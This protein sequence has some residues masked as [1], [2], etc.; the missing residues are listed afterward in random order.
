MS[1][2]EVRRAKDI[3]VCDDC[4]N[5]IYINENYYSKTDV[6]NSWM[7]KKFVTTRKCIACYNIR[8]VNII[9]TKRK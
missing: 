3:Q 5:A 4:G 9:E 7:G 1:I 8:K 2:F 6:Y